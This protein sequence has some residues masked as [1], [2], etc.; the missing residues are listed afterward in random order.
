M[1]QSPGGEFHGGTTLSTE[2]TR[3][4]ARG[5]ALQSPGGEFHGGTTTTLLLTGG[6]T[7]TTLQSPGGEFHGGTLFPVAVRTSYYRQIRR[8]DKARPTEPH[9]SQRCLLRE[10]VDSD[11]VPLAPHAPDSLHQ[12]LVLGRSQVALEH[13]ALD[14]VPVAGEEPCQLRPTTVIGNVVRYH[15]VA[16]T[17]S[18]GL[19]NAR[20]WR[21]AGTRPASRC[22]WPGPAP[23]LDAR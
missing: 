5:R 22:G 6:T 13:A 2:A 19:P 14:S 21:W 9:D 10:P 15:D 1:L 16:F 4:L 23:R 11:E 8:L 7:V 3:T 20:R 12:L 18:H 17:R